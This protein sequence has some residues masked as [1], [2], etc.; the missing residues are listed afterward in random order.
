MKAKAPCQNCTMRY[1]VEKDGKV[2]SCHSECPQ[3]SQFKEELAKAALQKKV[4]LAQ[5]TEQYIEHQ[6]QVTKALR[7][8]HRRFYA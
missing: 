6:T 7:K 4:F 2:V 5:F 3:Y 1:V 8:K